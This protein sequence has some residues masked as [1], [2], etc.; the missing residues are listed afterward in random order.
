MQ[1]GQK[2]CCSQGDF[3]DMRP[4]RE[5]DGSCASYYVIRDD[6][7]SKIAAKNDLTVNDLERFNK[8]TWGW[9]GCDRLQAKFTMCLSEGSP[10]FPAANPNAVCGP[11]KPGTAPSRSLSRSWAKL[12]PCPLKACCNIWGQCGTTEDFCID[13][14]TGNPGTSKGRNGCISNCGTTIV[15]N[16]KPPAEFRKIGYFEAWNKNRKCLRMDYTEV[17][18]NEYTHIHFAFPDITTG[19]QVDVSRVKDQF[20]KFVGT[21]GSSYKKIASLGGWAFSTE[22]ETHGIFRNGVRAGAREAFAANIADFVLKNNLDGIDIDWEYPGVP[23]MNWLPRSSP[24]EG[25]NYLEFLKLL[26]AKLPPNKSLSIAAP[27][28]FW[29]LKAFPIENIS[30]VVDYIVYMTYDL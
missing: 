4:K 19:Y 3:P 20:D 16:N 9:N 13:Q 26:R 25:P 21:T 7:C 17:P 11:T 23:D 24:D 1:P 28:S 10:P 14:S 30:K 5:P 27:A 6:S 22:V 12:N 2:L 18:P 15:N 29:Y 8:D